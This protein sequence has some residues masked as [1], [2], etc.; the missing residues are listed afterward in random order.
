M[1]DTKNESV[2][3]TKEPRGKRKRSQTPEDVPP[4][5]KKRAPTKE[6]TGVE[7]VFEEID[8]RMWLTETINNLTKKG[9]ISS[10]FRIVELLRED[11][12]LDTERLLE[13]VL[14][15]MAKDKQTE[16]KAKIEAIQPVSEMIQFQIQQQ[17]RDSYETVHEARFT[18]ERLAIRVLYEYLKK[19]KYHKREFT[20]I[21]DHNYRYVAVETPQVPPRPYTLQDCIQI[22]QS[23][24]ERVKLS[25]YKGL[26]IKRFPCNPS[27]IM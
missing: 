18:S 15:E 12:S 16:W 2:E 9:V 5:T 19:E 20:V 1:E 8:Q 10:T 22:I 11:D 4:P 6:T 27:K 7:N 21:Q 25:D 17:H 14:G 24:Q 26:L 23:K 13:K 3:E